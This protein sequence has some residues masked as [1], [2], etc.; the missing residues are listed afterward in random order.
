MLRRWVL[1]L[2]L[3]GGLLL[4]A[5]GPVATPQPAP[6]LTPT[7]RITPALTPTPTPAPTLTPTPTP[8]PASTP[9]PTPAHTPT[10]TPT[11]T[12]A[13]TPTPAPAP[14]SPPVGSLNLIEY[15]PPGP[16]RDAVVNEC[17]NCHNLIRII[18]GRWSPEGWENFI[19][20]HPAA[21]FIRE[22]TIRLLID[23]LAA[24]CGPDDPIPQIPP[25]LWYGGAGEGA[26]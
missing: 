25:E 19:R 16:G 22:Q 15:L 3:A 18:Q 26:A 1:I 21:A 14:W 2:V 8:T 11:P 13:S 9:T 12:P 6:A 20:G 24:S 4:A 23:Y 7:P 10:V 17:T 5:C